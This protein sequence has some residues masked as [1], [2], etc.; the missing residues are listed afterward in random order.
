[1][2]IISHRGYWKT[3]IEKNTSVAFER[4]FKLGFGTETD[5]RD[6]NGILVISHDIPRGNEIYFSQFLQHYIDTKCKGTLAINIKSDGLHDLIHKDL[7]KYNIDKYFIFDMSIPDTVVA[8]NYSLKVFSRYSEYEN[9]TPLWDKSDGIWYDNFFTDEFDGSLLEDL[10]S[11]G[12]KV[13]IVSAE[14][15][16]RDYESQWSNINLLNNKSLYSNN[17]ILCTDFPVLAQEYF[18]E[19]V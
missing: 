12:K 2:E 17:L 18:N 11:S 14:L 7:K 1:M 5:V 9:K 13:C 3:D 6:N 4:S 15:H 10:I 19:Y 8:F 16:K